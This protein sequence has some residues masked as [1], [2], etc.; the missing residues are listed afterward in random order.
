MGK[1]TDIVDKGYNVGKSF[2]KGLHS[3]LYLPF[4]MPT[5]MRRVDICELGS[6]M[7]T[8][9]DYLGNLISSASL[10]G[11][12]YILASEFDRLP[13]FFGALALTNGFDCLSRIIYPNQKR[14]E[15]KCKKLIK[16]GNLSGFSEYISKANVNIGQDFFRKEY[17]TAFK[18]GNIDD[19]LYLFFSSPEFPNDYVESGILSNY[20]GEN[21][22][23]EMK[24]IFEILKENSPE[25]VSDIEELKALLQEEDSDEVMTTIFNKDVFF[26]NQ[27]IREAFKD[28]IPEIRSYLKPFCNDEQ[29]YIN[30]CKQL[31]NQ[32]D[33][34]MLNLFCELGLSKFDIPQEIN[35]VQE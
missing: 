13:E 10:L 20:V 35:T 16:K 12:S 31:L 26:S 14:D 8:L 29:A 32:K 24:D 33:Y 9:S 15:S 11:T 22:S 17:R 21:A 7:D 5:Y 4:F 30:K 27:E 19:A 6:F 23:K 18:N 34:P 2:V 28:Y 3:G 1:L 25:K